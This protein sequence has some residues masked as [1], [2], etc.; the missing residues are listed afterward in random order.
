[1]E[2][3][4][5]AVDGGTPIRKKE[6]SKWPIYDETEVEN[7]KS[8][9][10]SGNWWRVSGC[11]VNEFEKKFAEY[12]SAN[13]CIGTTNGTSALEIALL[14]LG[15]TKGDEII[16][17]AMTFISTALPILKCGAVPVLVDI[18]IDNFCIKT[19]LIESVITKKSKAIIPVHMAGHACDM[20]KIVDI[21]KKYNLYII[22]DA[23]HA[24][25]G[26]YKNKKI[27]SFGDAA[28]FSFQNGKLMTCGEGGAV[29][30]KSKE[31]YDY[32]YLLQDVGRPR[33]DKE[34][35]HLIFAGNYRM[36][37][38]QAAILL[39]QLN[40]VKIMNDTREKNSKKLDNLLKCIKGITPQRKE[41]YSTCTT[42]YMYM[43]YYDKQFFGNIDRGQFVELLKS[44]GIP[45]HVCF[46]AIYDAE[47]LKNNSLDFID[48]KDKLFI[49]IESL[50]NAKRIS[51][52]V[53]CLPHSVIDGSNEDLYDVFNSIMK[54]QYNLQENINA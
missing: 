29:V 13:Y 28:I 32:A 20:D 22:E 17:P 39:A 14:S 21:A 1:M 37:E 45:A 30:F 48:Y 6:F 51:Q 35:Q 54:I 3:N 10:D 27:G 47:F 25:G 53:V 18:D 15:I 49:N 31:I 9:L 24:H 40:R 43:F 46:P 33:G 7:I 16:I 2:Q 12:H 42:H 41:N 11:K 26:E 23:A 8:V 38:F 5:L 19:D 44:E 50:S 34:Y 4:R 52:N 36:N